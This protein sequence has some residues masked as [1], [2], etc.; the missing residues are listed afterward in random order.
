MNAPVLIPFGQRLHALLEQHEPPLSQA[1]LADRSGLDRSLIS[2]IIRCERNPTSEALQSL[3]PALQMDIADLVRGTNAESRLHETSNLVQRQA[4]E[5]AIRTLTEYEAR[6]RDLDAQMRASR[7]A[8]V[9]EERRRKQAERETSEAHLQ[10]QWAQRDLTDAKTHIQQQA[11]DLRQ[12]QQALFK[13][14]AEIGV[15]QTQFRELNE[16]LASTKKSSRAG[17]ILAG[18]AAITGVVTVAHFLGEDD[19]EPASSPEPEPKA[20]RKPRS[21]K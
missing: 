7:E 19:N 18:V 10:I 17:A 21:P 9:Q 5:S 1:W 16:E 6:L 13:A 11:Q 4:Y 8:L 15:L 3:A 14:V 20:T 12:Y 2:R